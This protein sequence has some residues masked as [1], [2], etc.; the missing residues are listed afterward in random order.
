MHSILA[1]IVFLIHL[2]YILFVVFGAL[3]VFQWRWVRWIHIPAV[4]WA[5]FVELT[6]RICPLTPWE[7]W[8]RE[9]GGRAPYAGGF[10]DHYLVPLVY[11][12][13]LTREFQVALGVGVIILNGALYFLIHHQRIARSAGRQ[14]R[15]A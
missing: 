4:L 6:G 7:N 5:A 8:F 11:P 14:S 15:R 10:I 13:N 3:L 2:A 9:V 1:D 12:E